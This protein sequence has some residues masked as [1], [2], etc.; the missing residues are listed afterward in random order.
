MSVLCVC[1]CVCFFLFF[2]F[3]RGLF[4]GMFIDEDFFYEWAMPCMEK[5]A[6]ELKARH[7]DVPLMAFPRGVPI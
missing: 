7:P 3:V 6:T 2:F 1:V 5:I 4:E